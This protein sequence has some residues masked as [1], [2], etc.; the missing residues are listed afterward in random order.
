MKH[1]QNEKKKRWGLHR[2]TVDSSANLCHERNLHKD[3]F[4]AAWRDIAPCNPLQQVMFRKQLEVDLSG[5]IGCVGGK[6]ICTG[7]IAA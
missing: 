7:N 3:L 5:F 1:R 2:Q 4:N 6:K